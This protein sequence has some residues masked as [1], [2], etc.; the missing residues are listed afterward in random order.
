MIKKSRIVVGL[1]SLAIVMLGGCASKPVTVDVFWDTSL[2]QNVTRL[3]DDGL[4]KSWAKISPDG[5]KMLY[6]EANKHSQWNIILL[7]DVTVP[8]KT[9]LITD[10][11][12]AP[13]WYENNNNYLFVAVEG[14]TG[15]IVRSAI[16]GGGKTYV[17]RNPVGSDD[18][19]PVIKN[20][21]ILCDT[22]ANNRRQLISMKDNGTEVTILGDG[23]SPSWHP[24]Q[25]KFVF[26]RE[27]AND[28][29]N[30]VYEMDLASVQVTQI[31]SETGSRCGSPSYSSNGQYIL[32]QKQTAQNITGTMVERV[33]GFLN[34]VTK[35]KGTQIKWQIY[36]IKSDGTSL[37]PLTMGSVDAYSPSWVNDFVYFISDASGKTELY[38][39][40]IN[41][42]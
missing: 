21:A 25:S 14:G 8:A 9:P 28:S 11:A 17:T 36:T 7:R 1:L 20:G 6:C 16:T 26:I 39:A 40:R 42:N 38:R 37:S 3:T 34:K 10:S 2:L 24:T 27:N 18:T 29:G 13:S 12:Y 15:K 19:R 32:F 33:G 30:S 41:F 31:F 23:H 35:V 5:T 4:L 22:L